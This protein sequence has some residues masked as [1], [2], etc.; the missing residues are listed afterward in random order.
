MG[1]TTSWGA[2]THSFPAEL[3]AGMGAVFAA[4][5]LFIGIRMAYEFVMRLIFR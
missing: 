3:L 5:G 1:G 2:L 4:I